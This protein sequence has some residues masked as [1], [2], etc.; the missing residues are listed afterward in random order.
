[1]TTDDQKLNEIL[2]ETP[3]SSFGKKTCV[4]GSVGQSYEDSADDWGEPKDPNEPKAKAYTQWSSPD[5]VTFIP[6]NKTVQVLTPG[7]YEINANP[8]MGLFFQK[9]PVRTEGLL[10]FSETNSDKVVEEITKFWEKADRFK[11]YDLA[12][13][14]GILLWGPPGSGKS[15]TIQLIMNDVIERNGVVVKF[16]DPGLFVEGMRTLRCIQPDCPIVVIMEDIDSILD[17]YN[18]SNVLNILDGVNEVERVVFLATTNYP[19]KLGG[20][21]V[22]RPSRFDK[23]FMIGFPSK[24]ARRK[25]FEYIIGKDDLQDIDLDRWVKDTDEFSIAHLKEL[26]IAVVIL[27]DKYEDAIETLRSMRES[28]KESDSGESIMGFHSAKSDDEDDN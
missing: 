26:F 16:G 5:G 4:S 6:T 27:G 17:I 28:I 10:R 8:S 23:R 7:V 19:G 25:Y 11:K 15:C 2:K 14:R 1:M 9:I 18:E 20:R 21:I 24:K 22:N 12:Y 3:I 13:K